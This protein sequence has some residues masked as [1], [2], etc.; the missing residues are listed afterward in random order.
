MCSAFLSYPKGYEEEILL[1][2]CLPKAW[3]EGS[4]RGMGLRGGYTLDMSWKEGKL[5]HAK[6]RKDFPGKEK[7]VRVC[8]EGQYEIRY[9][10]QT[11]DIT[12]N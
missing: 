9:D 12:V 6:L 4:V 11:G 5:L 10:Q 7:T 3:P 8:T 1:L 2:P